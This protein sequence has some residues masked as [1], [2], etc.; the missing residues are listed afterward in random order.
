MEVPSV[1]VAVTVT[2]DGAG[3][4]IYDDAE[5]LVVV[6]LV[7]LV[8]IANAW[9]AENECELGSAGALTVVLNLSIEPLVLDLTT[10]GMYLRRPFLVHNV[11]VAD[12]KTRV[13]P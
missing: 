8:D 9:N 10:K 6:A 2:T 11:L 1:T 13:V 7:P 12:N 3:G 4:V 5:A